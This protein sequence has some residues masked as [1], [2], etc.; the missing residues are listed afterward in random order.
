MSTAQMVSNEYH[1]H[2]LLQVCIQSLLLPKYANR[3]F[4]I[5]SKPAGKGWTFPEHVVHLSQGA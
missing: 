3:S 5:V 4:D 2:F 1:H